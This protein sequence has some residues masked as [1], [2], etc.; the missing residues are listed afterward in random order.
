[1]SK[2]LKELIEALIIASMLALFIR[3][4]VLQAYTIPSGSMLET[5]QIGDYLMVNKFQYGTKIPF[6]RS[7][8]WKGSDPEY[9]DIIVFEYPDG[10]DTT[11]IKRIVGVPG[12][13][14]EMRGKVL[15]RNGVPQEEPYAIYLATGYQAY[16]GNFGPVT[17]PADSYFC[18]GD[19]R[20]FS[21]DSRFWENMFVKRETIYGKAWRI[22]WSITEQADIRWERLG[23]S[24][25]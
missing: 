6:T 9:G 23:Q 20:D 4:F 19:N 15:Y 24:V 10:P 11:Y 1:M 12:D 18:M 3:A 25:H 16:R 8:L 21:R 17:V 5:L 13:T 14:I 22:Y 2:L 7:Y